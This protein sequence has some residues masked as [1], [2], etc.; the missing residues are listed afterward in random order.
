MSRAGTSNRA[1]AR[2]ALRAFNPSANMDANHGP[3]APASDDDIGNVL[4]ARIY[5]TRLKVNC[6]LRWKLYWSRSMF[7]RSRA[8]MIRPVSGLF[9]SLAMWKLVDAWRE[10]TRQQRDGVLERLGCV[11][12]LSL[13]RTFLVIVNKSAAEGQRYSPSDCSNLLTAL[14]HWYA[15]KA[16]PRFRA[17]LA[18]SVLTKVFVN[19]ISLWYLRIT[20]FRTMRTWAFRSS[21]SNR[22]LAARFYRSIQCSRVFALLKQARVRAVSFMALCNEHL[23]SSANNMLQRCMHSWNQKTEGSKTLRLRAANMG[24]HACKAWAF[25]EWKVVARTLLGYKRM[26]IRQCRITA[27]KFFHRWYATAPFLQC[28]IVTFA[29][30][31]AV[32][33]QPQQPTQCQSCL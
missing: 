1:S 14:F 8:N 7:L 20:A 30:V 18:Y 33:C 15:H 2:V 17:L 29:Q 4:Y 31:P 11:S 27:V 23:L 5:S 21:H 25:R 10:V 24:M 28:I 16:R 9:S 6:L 12:N 22:P 3:Q 26:F 13:K 19:K 32:Q